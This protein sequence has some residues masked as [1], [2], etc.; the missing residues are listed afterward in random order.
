MRK[1]SRQPLNG[2]HGLFN[3]FMLNLNARHCLRL[4][5]KMKTTRTIELSLAISIVEVASSAIH[6]AEKKLP[7]INSHNELVLLADRRCDTADGQPRVEDGL[8]SGDRAPGLLGAVL[9]ASEQDWN[10]RVSFFL[11]HLR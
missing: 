8:A 5:L 1:S 10:D 11:G 6:K 9:E 3:A 7:S 2:A 4:A